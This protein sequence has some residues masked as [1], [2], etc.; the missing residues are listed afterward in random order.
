M[1]ETIRFDEL[2]EQ[3]GIIALHLKPGET[4]VIG[5]NTLIAEFSNEK[6]EFLCRKPGISFTVP[7]GD[8]W[9]AVSLQRFS[10]LM[11]FSDL[12]R[13]RL[14]SWP[15]RNF[16]LGFHFEMGV[17]VAHLYGFKSCIAEKE[18]VRSDDVRNFLKNPA[19][20]TVQNAVRSVLEP[21]LN[22]DECRAAKTLLEQSIEKMLF[23]YLYE[24]GVCIIPHTLNIRS[25]APPAIEIA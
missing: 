23:P 24:K 2:N 13:Y 15:G 19:S 14:P 8:H 22:Y 7:A 12:L 21:D 16:Q 1:S 20:V 6:P 11:G 5:T 9:Y 3:Q 25:F 17:F 4:A 18:I 10:L